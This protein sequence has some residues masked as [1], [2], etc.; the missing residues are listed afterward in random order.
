MSLSSD[1]NPPPWNSFKQNLKRDLLGLVLKNHCPLCQRST[2]Q[3]LCVDCH[4][5][6]SQSH[7]PSVSQ[8][9]RDLPPILA[10]GHYD[11][12]LKRAIAALKYNNHPQLAQPL[13]TWMAQAWLATPTLCQSPPARVVPIPLHP[14]RLQERGFNQADLLARSFCTATRLQR[15]AGLER[16]K[17]T[18]AQFQLSPTARV[19]NLTDA[20]Q[21][22][23]SLQQ[24]RDV[25][26]VLLVDDIFTTGATL[27]EAVQTLRRRGIR[28]SGA[29]VLARAS[30]LGT[31]VRSPGQPLP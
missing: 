2:A 12:V 21:I 16:P 23:R 25:P 11:G 9:T 13:G 3:T 18:A 27:C 28:V 22:S 8:A 24:Q 14:S 4:R 15:M 17:A 26:T 7:A 5:S 19:T 31:G 20:F 6:L 1:M 29:I 10:W 30:G